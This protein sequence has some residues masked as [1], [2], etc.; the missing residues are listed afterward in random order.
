MN[1]RTVLEAVANL[2]YKEREDDDKAVL[3]EVAKDPNWFPK[4]FKKRDQVTEIKG[5]YQMMIWATRQE[6]AL[7]KKNRPITRQVTRYLASH[8]PKH[9]PPKKD[10]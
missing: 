6:E 10:N 2:H 4:S 7:K 3:A 5:T 8:S 9:L 1:T